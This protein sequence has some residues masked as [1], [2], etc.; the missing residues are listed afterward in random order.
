MSEIPRYKDSNPIVELTAVASSAQGY[1]AFAKTLGAIGEHAQKESET[2]QGEHSNAMYINSIAQSQK[3]KTDA[4][5]RMLKNPGQSAKIASQ[6]AEQLD[7]IQQNAYVNSKDRSRLKANVGEFKNTVALKAAATQVNQSQNEAAFTHYANWHDQLQA[8]KDM[9][10]QDPAKAEHMHNAMVSNL[11]SLVSIGALTPHEAGSSIKDMQAVVTDSHDMLEYMQ[12][13]QSGGEVNAKQYQTLA[14]SPLSNMPANPGSPVNENTAWLVEQHNSDRTFQGLKAAIA[15]NKLLPQAFAAATATQRQEALLMMQGA[16]EADG[17]INSGEPFPAMEKEFAALNESHRVLS[18]RETG[19]RDR[20]ASYLNDMKSGNYLSAI[21]KTPMG[22]GMMQNFNM[23]NEAINNSPITDEQKA[24]QLQQNKNNLVDAA[25]SYGEGHHMPEQYV[26]PIPAQDVA[27]MQNAFKLGQDPAA[28]V[29]VLRSYSPQ[30]QLYAANA[31]KDPKQRVTMQT[32]ALAGTHI[33]DQ[34]AQDFI[35]AQQDGRS[36]K[37][38]DFASQKEVG[39]DTLINAVNTNI[40]DATKVINSQ[41]DSATASVLNRNLVEAGMNY[42]KYISEKKGQF[43]VKDNSTWDSSKNVKDSAALINRAYAPMTGANYI[44]NKNQVDITQPEMD[45]VAQWAI[46]QGNNYLKKHVSEADYI[47]I[48]DRGDLTVSV[49]PKGTLQAK[50]VYGNVY[51][52]TIF[53]SNLA[54]HAAVE[55]KKENNRIEA[56]NASQYLAPIGIYNQY[57][58]ENNK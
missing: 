30:N 12:Y 44:V 28:A 2:I 10:V 45:N 20:L 31:L 7:S 36:R 4:E 57:S 17:M 51:F 58:P 6:T 37:E 32:V 19:R 43:S 21:T 50:D 46:N 24:Q 49:T 5:I 33:T 9:L 56:E 39:D 18:Y 23:K 40:I 35:A 54:A 41:Y 55:V 25:I 22:N 48:R 52:S 14:S 53:T 8:Y 42:A 1:E 13:A 29:Q 15:N 3:V 47:G 11:H 26:Q 38:I 34:E 27:V 16:R